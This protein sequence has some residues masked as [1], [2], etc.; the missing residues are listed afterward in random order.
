MPSAPSTKK[1]EL[2]PN[3]PVFHETR[4]GYLAGARKV[5]G[6]YLRSNALPKWF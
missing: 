6:D 2:F 3:L 5:S 1:L 4:H